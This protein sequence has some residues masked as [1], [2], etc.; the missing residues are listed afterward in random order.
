MAFPYI[1]HSNFEAGTNAEWDTES[2]SDGVITYPHYSALAGIPWSRAA[3][4]SGAYCM[5]IKPAGG[6][7]DST[8]AEADINIA[9][10][11]TNY[12]RFDLYFGN[13]FAA[14]ADD[15]FVLL[16]LLGTGPATV[17]SLGCTITATSGNIVMA[18]G[19]ATT[20]AT[21]STDGSLIIQRNT[22]YTIEMKVLIHLTNAGTV[23]VFITK[24]GDVAQTTADIALSSQDHIAV[25]DGLF[26]LQDHETTTTG[27]ILLDNFIQDDTGRIFPDK[28]FSRNPEITKSFHAFIGPGSI[29]GAALLSSSGSN[30]MKLWDTDVAD[31]NQDFKVELDQDRNTSFTGPL[32]F[33]KGCYVSLAGTSPRG[34]VVFQGNSTEGH[35]APLHHSPATMRRWG[36]Q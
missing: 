6:S 9:S 2:D 33:Q 13:D 7:A 22:W 12:F 19:S 10:G 35:V 4:F 8:L 31:T 25:E 1:F 17:V 21:P 28:R 20:G 14:T 32:F 23:D 30:V 3:P 24:D 29:D 16:E 11:I 18:A 5:Q 27:T 36:Q 15:T 26:G 34:Q